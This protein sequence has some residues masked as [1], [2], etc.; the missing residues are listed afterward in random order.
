[1]LKNHHSY[2][3]HLL[4]LVEVLVS[5]TYLIDRFCAMYSDPTASQTTTTEPQP[6]SY[7]EWFVATYPLTDDG[8]LFDL[9]GALSS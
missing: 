5:L 3:S 1:M 8:H 7:A 6:C 9:R 4:I 2:I